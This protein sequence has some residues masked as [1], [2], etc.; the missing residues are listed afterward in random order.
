M[1]PQTGQ[2][3]KIQQIHRQASA[4]TEAM[5]YS[6]N[7][8]YLTQ[9][10][11]ALVECVYQ[12]PG[13]AFSY[14]FLAHIAFAARPSYFIAFLLAGACN[15]GIAIFLWFSAGPGLAGKTLLF[16]GGLFAGRIS[17]V[18]N[19]LFAAYLA[20]RGLWV[21]A[22]LGLAFAVGLAALI[23]PSTFIYASLSQGMNAKYSIAK[24]LFGIKFPFEQQF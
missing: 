14:A 13:G 7:N 22:A 17:S 9:M 24:K 19:I 8:Q 3:E 15:A 21:G 11:K 1:E 20:Y 2:A 18:I 6:L 4:Y 5:V 16:M 10:Q 12:V 23:Q